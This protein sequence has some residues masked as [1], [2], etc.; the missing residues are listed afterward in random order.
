MRRMKSLELKTLGLAAVA[1]AAVLATSAPAEAKKSLYLRLGGQPAIVAVVR[2]FV[3]N[4]AG[5]TRINSFFAN[6]NIPL[7]K[8]DLIDQVCQATGGPCKYTGKDMKTVHKGMGI[9]TANFNAMVDDL[10]ISLKKFH[11]KR[12][13]RNELLGA[14]ASMKGDIVEKP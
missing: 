1:I 10:V 11:V 14:L 8:S 3:G 6:A 7:L 2:D 4:V 13:E 5:D 12:R 9:S